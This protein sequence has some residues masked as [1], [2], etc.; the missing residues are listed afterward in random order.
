MNLLGFDTSKAKP[1]LP[2]RVKEELL[3]LE[4][5][6]LPVTTLCFADGLELIFGDEVGL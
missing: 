5:R 6:V 1:S 2:A 3:W 4:H